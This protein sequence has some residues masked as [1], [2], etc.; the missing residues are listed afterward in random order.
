MYYV[1]IILQHACMEIGIRFIETCTSSSMLLNSQKA[2]HS[3]LKKKNKFFST[4]IYMHIFKTFFCIEIDF[5]SRD[6][7]SFDNLINGSSVLLA[8]HEGCIFHENNKTFRHGM[9][10]VYFICLDYI[11][12]LFLGSWD[13]VRW[14]IVKKKS[15]QVTRCLFEV[16]S[17][18]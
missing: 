9:K 10:N 4:M 17:K 13:V 3:I 16:V 12:F 1:V 7:L 18:R 8:I 5:I 6:L 14:C 2:I 15:S 11:M